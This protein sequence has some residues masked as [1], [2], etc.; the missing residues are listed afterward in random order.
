MASDGKNCWE[1]INCGAVKEQCAAYP[2]A[3]RS[4]AYMAGTVGVCAAGTFDQKK[5]KCSACSFFNSEHFEN[6]DLFAN[7]Y[8][9]Q[10]EDDLF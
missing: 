6:T 1:F 7:R 4:C 10:I 5:Q 9:W 2:D 3:G 8:G